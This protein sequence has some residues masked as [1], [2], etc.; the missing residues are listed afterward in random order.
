MRTATAHIW[1]IGGRHDLISLSV[2]SHHARILSANRN[3][4]FIGLIPGNTANGWMQVF[5][6]RMRHTGT[7]SFLAGKMSH[8]TPSPW[9]VCPEGRRTRVT[10]WLKTKKPGKKVKE[11][12]TAAL[13][14]WSNRKDGRQTFSSPRRRRLSSYS[15][16]R[17]YKDFDK[18]GGAIRNV[19][20]VSAV[21]LTWTVARDKKISLITMWMF[22]TLT[23]PRLANRFVSLLLMCLSML[24]SPL[25]MRTAC[26]RVRAPR[27]TPTV[28][29]EPN[30]LG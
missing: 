25:E 12:Y 15:V 14:M 30:T 4:N 26:Q 16:C 5:L 2:R 10:Q 21:S 11:K 17:N 28:L 1:G 27:A 19:L 18:P 22:R 20:K 7:T 6:R 8:V 29:K 9:G 3:N 23:F 13:I 24:V